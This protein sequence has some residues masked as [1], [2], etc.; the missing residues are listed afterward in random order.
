MPAARLERIIG[1]VLRVGVNTSTVCLACG[2]A[3][4]FLSGSPIASILL[5][6]GIVIL[7][8]TP[9]ARVV[10]SIVQY[11]GERDWTFT[12]LTAIVLVELLASVAAALVFHRKL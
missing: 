5:Q 8:A 7:F 10:V 1:T 12:T 4:F 6:A 9:V 3:L 11:A 2:V